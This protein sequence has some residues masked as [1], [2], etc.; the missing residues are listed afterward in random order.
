[1]GFACIAL[2]FPL[3]FRFGMADQEL[4]GVVMIADIRLISETLAADTFNS[5]A[6][7]RTPRP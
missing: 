4:R 7:S 1:M 5:R 6:V 2:E 3:L